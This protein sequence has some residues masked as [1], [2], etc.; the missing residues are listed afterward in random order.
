MIQPKRKKYLINVQCAF[1]AV[2][3]STTPPAPEYLP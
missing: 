2:Y 3:F 1:I